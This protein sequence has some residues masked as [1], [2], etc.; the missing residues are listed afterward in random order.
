M[1]KISLFA[2]GALLFADTSAM[3]FE[4]DEANNNNDIKAAIKSYSQH[5]TSDSA[6]ILLNNCLLLKDKLETQANT[7]GGKPQ[8]FL[9]LFSEYLESAEEK[10]N[11]ESFQKNGGFFSSLF[12]SCSCCDLNGDGNVDGKDLKILLGNALENIVGLLG[13]ENNAFDKTGMQG[14]ILSLLSKKQ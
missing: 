5:L 6:E 9:K 1:K 2:M 11:K 8:D 13:N 14:I 4:Y 3:N 10:E 7:S 12:S